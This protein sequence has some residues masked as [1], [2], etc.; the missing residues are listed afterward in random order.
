[1]SD[2]NLNETRRIEALKS[3]SEWSKWTISV[4]AISVVLVA[5]GKDTV[6]QV[7]EAN[8]WPLFIAAFLL[9]FS[10][11]A[12]TILVGGIPSAIQDTASNRGRRK[13]IHQYRALTFCQFKGFSFQFLALIEH[14]FF[15]LALLMFL[16]VVFL[17]QSVWDL[18]F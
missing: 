11:L 16:L 14:L 7:N 5:I 4:Q 18:L 3:L 6:I 8:T 9:F 12:A 1:M 10:V 17:P 13:L 2:K 15:I